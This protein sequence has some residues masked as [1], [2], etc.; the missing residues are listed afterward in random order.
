MVVDNAAG[1][2]S[3]IGSNK[4]AKASPDG[5]TLLLNHIAMA[6]MPSLLRNM[7]FKVESDFEYLGMINDVPMTLIG[8]P[9]LSADQLQGPD[10]L[11]QPEQGQDQ[12]GQCRCR[13]GIAPVRPAVSKRACRW[14]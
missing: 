13:L 12:P 9:S 3:S 2:G 14:T 4:V 6:T 10:G 7:P 8:R 5:H 11:D 1:A